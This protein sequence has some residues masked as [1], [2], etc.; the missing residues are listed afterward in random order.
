MGRGAAYSF[1]RCLPSP[2]DAQRPKGRCVCCAKSSAGYC[3]SG[4]APHTAV[5]PKFPHSNSCKRVPNRPLRVEASV[6]SYTTPQRPIRNYFVTV[7]SAGFF[8][9]RLYFGIFQPGDAPQ[10]GVPCGDAMGSSGPPSCHDLPRSA[11]VRFHRPVASQ[12]R[13][14][15]PRTSHAVLFVKLTSTAPWSLLPTS[16]RPLSK[17]LPPSCFSV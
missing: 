11:S 14:H 6:G 2:M 13:T 15:L 5:L 9:E 4:G 12:A 10:L 1:G 7:L 17:S 3:P 16:R 8:G